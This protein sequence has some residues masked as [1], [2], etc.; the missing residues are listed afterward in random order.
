VSFTDPRW[1]LR[2]QRRSV[3]PQRFRCNTRVPLAYLSKSIHH[4]VVLN[5]VIAVPYLR[6]QESGAACLA[7]TLDVD[8]KVIDQHGRGMG[9]LL[10]VRRKD[11]VAIRYAK[12]L[13]E[14]LELPRQA[15]RRSR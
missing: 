8:V 15:P 7:E 14:P 9:Q 10:L 2:P 12:P 1:S 5:L 3:F 6:K 11:E 13:L 4:F